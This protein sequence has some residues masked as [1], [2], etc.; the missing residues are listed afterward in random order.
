MRAKNFTSSL[1]PNASL[2][3]TGTIPRWPRA[4]QALLTPRDMFDGAFSILHAL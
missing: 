1:R 4:P 2:L 3:D